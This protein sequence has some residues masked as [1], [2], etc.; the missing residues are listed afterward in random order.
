MSINIAG[1]G[2]ASSSFQ[3]I[4]GNS[5]TCQSPPGYYFPSPS[6]LQVYVPIGFTPATA[7]NLYSDIGLTQYVTPSTYFFAYNSKIYK[8]TNNGSPVYIGNDLY[9]P[10]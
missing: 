2:V 4:K 7:S 3:I 1:G 6:N 5:V 10:C 9:D 8:V